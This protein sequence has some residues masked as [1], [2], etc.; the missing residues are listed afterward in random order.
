MRFLAASGNDKQAFLEDYHRQ[1]K[2][3]KILVCL[4]PLD[5]STDP[6]VGGDIRSQKVKIKVNNLIS[7][8]TFACIE[9]SK[10]KVFQFFSLHMVI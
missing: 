4:D 7:A 10:H 1:T 5:P 8:P 3:W 6:N 9:G 2:N